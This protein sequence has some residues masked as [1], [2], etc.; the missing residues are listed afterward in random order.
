MK[1]M[2]EFIGKQEGQA[3]SEIVIYE[4]G[5]TRLSLPLDPVHETVWASQSQIGEL[6]GIDQSGVS[7]HL[8]NIFRDQE[9]DEQS[10]M[11]KLHIAHADR[12]VSYYSLDVILSVGYRTNSPAAI[13]FRRWASRILKQYALKGVAL[14]ERRLEQIGQVVKFLSRSSD[15]WLETYVIAGEP[16]SGMICLNGAAAASVSVSDTIIIMC[17]CQLDATEAAARYGA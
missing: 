17:Y 16:G 4:T 9:V 6:F 8:R 2:D 11:Q 1:D 5:T 12:P 15:T 7:R 14:N 10:N 3:S 13:T